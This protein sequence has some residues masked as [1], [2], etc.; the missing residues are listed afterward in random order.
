MVISCRKHQWC[1]PNSNGFKQI[2]S[3]LQ[4]KRDRIAMTYNSMK[5]SFHFLRTSREEATL[6]GAIRRA[7]RPIWAVSRRRF[8]GQ[9]CA[10]TVGV[11][12]PSFCL[13]LEPRPGAALTDERGR[14]LLTETGEALGWS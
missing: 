6:L 4:A 1:V 3:G 5:Y 12:A 13:A 7:T 8:L 10:A 11:S 14:P 2:P 9:V